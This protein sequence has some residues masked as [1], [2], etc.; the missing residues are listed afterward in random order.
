MKTPHTDAL[1][2]L[3]LAARVTVTIEAV[4]EEDVAPALEEGEAHRVVGGRG[5]GRG[6]SA[7]GGNNAGFYRSLDDQHPGSDG[8][9]NSRNG[10]GSSGGGV[11]L[12]NY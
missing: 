7:S 1:I 11:P 12:M 2:R 5:R 10:Q 6:G 9:Y 8:T 4:A 3:G